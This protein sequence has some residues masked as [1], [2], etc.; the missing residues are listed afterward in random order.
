MPSHPGSRAGLG[1]GPHAMRRITEHNVSTPC[2]R[3]TEGRSM[4][5]RRFLAATR[6]H[7]SRAGS[8]IIRTMEPHMNTDI[9]RQT[10]ATCC[11]GRAIASRGLAIRCGGVDWTYAEF[12]DICNRFAAG[13]AAHGLEVGDRVAVTRRPVDLCPYARASCGA[14]WM[15]PCSAASRRPRRVAGSSARPARRRARSPMSRWRALGP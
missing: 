5:S 13:L 9:S 12:D 15:N 14:P 1:Q 8:R 3:V 11:A 10:W 2:Q 4:A 6:G 7:R